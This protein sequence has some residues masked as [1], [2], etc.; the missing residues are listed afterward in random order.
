MQPP[1]PHLHDLLASERRRRL[2]SDALPVAPGRVRGGL[3]RV[4]LAA[5]L[6]LTA[7]TTRERA[8]WN[9]DRRPVTRA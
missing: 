3:G 5:G 4:L 9:G 7:G 2:A 8:G 1:D 6:R